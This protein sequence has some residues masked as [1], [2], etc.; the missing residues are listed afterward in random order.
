M[1]DGARVLVV[2]DEADARTLLER[3][4]TR[5]GYTVVTAA[6]GEEAVR[7][8]DKSLAAIVTDLVMPR[9]DGVGVLTQAAK[10][11]PSA[12]R[13]VITSFADKDRAVAA[14]NSGAHYLVEKPFTTQQLVEVLGRLLAERDRSS[15]IDHLLENRLRGLAL[16][17]HEHQ[18]IVY[19]L[20][21]LSNQE[22]GKL[23]GITEQMVKNHLFQLYRKLNIA[24]RGELFHLIFPI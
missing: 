12:V 10:L 18:L 8:F 23:I 2:D 24:S 11:I 3:G 14:L 5:H 22:I 4:L 20:K 19:V 13:V 17:E 21:G 9:L 16:T 6:D 1:S 7:R 15:G